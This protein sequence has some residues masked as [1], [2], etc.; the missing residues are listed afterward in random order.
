MSILEHEESHNRIIAERSSRDCRHSINLDPKVP[1]RSEEASYYATLCMRHPM[2]SPPSG[3][4]HGG[5]SPL[6]FEK[7]ATLR[8]SK[9]EGQPE[10]QTLS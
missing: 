2:N 1:G 4:A 6:G 3:H 7:M 9:L 5:W 8:V 10:Y